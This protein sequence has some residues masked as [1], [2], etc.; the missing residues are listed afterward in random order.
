MFKSFFSKLAITYILIIIVVISLFSYAITILYEEG[1]FEDKK[2]SLLLAADEV[3]RL[4]QSYYQKELASEKLDSQL[5]TI[6]AITESRVY[7]LKL[8]KE[9][10]KNPNTLEMEKLVENDILKDIEVI[11]DDQIIFEKRKYFKELDTYAVMLG[12]PLKIDSKIEGVI[13]F[14]TPVSKLGSRINSIRLLVFTLAGCVTLI[15]IVVIYLNARRISRPVRQLEDAAMKL[16]MGDSPEDI[17]MNSQDEIGRLASTFNHMKNRLIETEQIRRDF[18]ANVSHDLRTPLTTIHGFTQGMLD[19]LVKPEQ[20]QKYLEII[21][22]ETLRLMRLTGDI[23]ELAKLEAGTIKMYKE[24]IDLKEVVE[25]LCTGMRALA[26]EKSI[27]LS[28]N[29]LEGIRLYVDEDRFRQILSNVIDNAVK[30]TPEGGSVQVNVREK[31]EWI[32]IVVKDTGL[33][34]SSENLPHIF[35]KFYR[36]DKAR[37]TEN[38][39]TGLGL[40]IVK[41][42]VELHGGKINVVSELGVGTEVVFKIPK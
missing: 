22:K 36:A 16:A 42:L 5:D 15:G 9:S 39:G 41:R 1:V 3:Q 30:Y 7:V 6:G 11:L 20:N 37:H 10:L 32:Q 14:L 31:G 25:E 18:I 19:G 28:I 34:I 24:Y 23:L 29:C 26:I 21:N 17:E 27:G 33:G 12:A 13:L 38:L 4:T 2:Q 35:E 40:S 8:N